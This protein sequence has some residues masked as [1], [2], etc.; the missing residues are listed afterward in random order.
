MSRPTLERQA[1]DR[2]QRTAAVAKVARAEAKMGIGSPSS[3]NILVAQLGTDGTVGG[4]GGDPLSADFTGFGLPA[5]MAVATANVSSLSGLQ[6]FDGYTLVNNDPV[7]LTGQ[8]DG[9]ANGPWIAHAGAWL[10]PDYYAHGAE[11]SGARTAMII[12]GTLHARESWCL[13][14]SPVTVDTTATAWISLGYEETSRKGQPNGYPELDSTGRIPAAR[15]T[16]SVVSVSPSGALPTPSALI[17]RNTEPQWYGSWYSIGNQN[18]SVG[19]AGSPT[20]APATTVGSGGVTLP[21]T[22]S[23]VPVADC[24]ALSAS[25]G[26]FTL[27]GFT[28]AYTGRS[29]SSGAGNAT[30]CYTT[31]AATGTYTSGTALGF[32]SIGFGALT[33]YQKFGDATGLTNTPIPGTTQAGYLIAAYYGPTVDD[34]MEGFSCFVAAKQTS[35]AYT[36]NNSVTAFEGHAQVESTVTATGIV[37]G[38]GSRVTV[39]GTA[40]GQVFGLRASTPTGGGTIAQYIAVG[41]SGS[42]AG[43][44]TSVF[45]FYGH[46]AIQSEKGLFVEKSGNGMQFAVNLAGSGGG[47]PA[48]VQITN[49]DSTNFATVRLNAISGQTLPLLTCFDSSGAQRMSVSDAGTLLMNGQ[50]VVVQESNVNCALLAQDGSVQPGVST[51]IGAGA[52]APG[53]K[54]YSGSG[55][56]SSL[57][58]VVGYI[59]VRTDASGANTFYRCTVTGAAGSATWKVIAGQV[60]DPYALAM[61]WQ[62]RNYDSALSASGSAPSTQVV[63]AVAIPLTEGQVV[64]NILFNVAAAGAGT[65]PTGIYVGL[66]N[67]T[68][69]LAVSNNLNA[70]SIWTAASSIAVAP[71]SASYTVPATGVYYAVILQNG[72]W[73]TT[74]MTLNRTTGANTNASSPLQQATGGTGQTTLTAGAITLSAA[75]SPLRFWAGAS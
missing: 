12:N 65:T 48:F 21:L 41:D 36:Q 43:L 66:A 69:L 33:L 35:G 59:Y 23:T 13:I 15:N 58:G 62:S 56:P 57:A 55:S 26:S 44:A 49:P 24:S 39:A 31:S 9:T 54:I 4:P 60:P 70:N 16:L 50:A 45:S 3:R 27:G 73:G 17:F 34:S 2:K 38:V 72:T 25:G 29:A 22:N 32:T 74:Q 67:T 6:T 68:T 52:A 20:S 8:T 37:L 5:C 51:A 7:L 75:S 30:G 61:G 11:T 18:A 1:A 10:R 46:D 47:T 40:S 71:L 64:S 14:T 19:F 63:Y 28:I 53:A 42:A